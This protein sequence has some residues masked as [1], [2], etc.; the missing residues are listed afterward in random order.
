[1][2]SF[3][4][5]F[6]V[7]LLVICSSISLVW[8][9]NQVKEGIS[10]S[11][12]LRSAY[13]LFD[14]VSG[15]AVR[16]KVVIAGIP[17]GR[18]DKIELEGNQAKVWVKVNLPLR[19]DARI[20]K[21]QASLLGESYL[22]LTPGLRGLTLSEGDRIRYVDVDVS[23]AELMEEVKGIMN[24]VN[25]ITL[26]LKNV[27]AGDNGEQRLVSILD[28][29]NRVVDQMNQALTG[30]SPK[31]DRVVTNVIEVTEEAKRF[32]REFRQKAN[33]ILV[34]ARVVS[35]NARQ[36]TGDVRDL[37]SEHGTS[38]QSTLRGAMSR[39][40]GS[41]AKLDGAI[42]SAQSIT[43]KIDRGEGTIGRLVNDDRLVDSVT[44]FVDESSRFVSRL[45]RLQFQVAMRSEFYMRDA[46]SKN[47]FEL[48]MRPRPDKY[49]LLQLVDSPARSVQLVDRVTTTSQNGS[50][51]TVVRESQSET[52]DRFLVS[53]QFAKRF[54][55]LT[56][57]V[58]ILENS[59]SLGLDAD[60]FNDRLNIIT[61]LFDFEANRNPRLRARAHYEFFTHLYIAAGIDDALNSN[62]RDYFIGGGIRFNDDDLAAILA[63]APTPSF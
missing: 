38:E 35:H 39:L 5:P 47:Y 61:D 18:V 14:D 40:Q 25:D 33:Q 15:L 41:L 58:G 8:M 1:M 49:Y 13:A 17:V 28:N 26:S 56:G 12:Q 32:T 2:N 63:T 55:F 9:S 59:G 60:F 50:M 52:R 6:K 7:G 42:A 51:P 22:Q 30:N 19:S 27:I 21:R 54:H 34:D 24:N 16:S 20:A 46:V 4:T 37:V 57:R 62:E 29:I 53:L 11:E 10:D 23:P 43:A 45:T 48:K 3:F 31:F 44:T 36:I